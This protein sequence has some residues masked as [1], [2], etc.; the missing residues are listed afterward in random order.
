M[1]RKVSAQNWGGTLS[2]PSSEQMKTFRDTVSKVSPREM[3]AMKSQLDAMSD[4]EKAEMM[5]K[6]KEMFGRG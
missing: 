4:A 1:E 5:R 3:A 6:M 2:H